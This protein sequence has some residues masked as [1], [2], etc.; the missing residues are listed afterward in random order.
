MRGRDTSLLWSFGFLAAAFSIAPLVAFSFSAFAGMGKAAASK[1]LPLLLALV[2]PSTLSALRFSLVQA[3][4]STVLALLVGFPGAFFVA[5]YDFRGRRFFMALAAVPFCLPAILVILSFILYYGKNGYF[6]LLLARVGFV[7]RGE[8][9]L[10]SIWG[11][12][13]VHA[14]YNFPIVIQNVGSVWAKMS[15]SREEAARTLGQESSDP[16][17]RYP[18]LS[19][20]SICNL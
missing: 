10:Y 20:P 19:P 13:F 11:L 14:F 3:A 9:L 18:A 1:T 4:L 15:R 5:R 6:S 8:G 17:S 7:P 16:C 12:V 2:S